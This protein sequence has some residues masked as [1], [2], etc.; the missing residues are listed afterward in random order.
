MTGSVQWN[1]F[2]ADNDRQGAME[3]FIGKN[4]PAAEF[5]P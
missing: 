2:L 1:S 3:L 5:N 4:L